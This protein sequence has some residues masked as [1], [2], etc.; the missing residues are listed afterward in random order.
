MAAS[1]TNAILCNSFTKKEKQDLL[2]LNHLSDHHST[3]L[4]LSSL[5]PISTHSLRNQTEPKNVTLEEKQLQCKWKKTLDKDYAKR[6]SQETKKMTKSIVNTN[7]KN[8]PNIDDFLGKISNAFISAADIVLKKHFRNKNNLKKC[9]QQK[10][11][12]PNCQQMRKNLN[13]LGRILTKNPNN[14][15]LRGQY[16]N[17]K[18]RYKATCKKEKRKFEWKLLQ[19]LENLYTNN[20]EEF[21]NLLKQIKSN[22]SSKSPEYQ[23]L[24]SLND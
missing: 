17:L 15:F 19:N 6:L 24:P 1:S 14:D 2:D 9:K 5:H 3:L 22:S 16:F 8:I 13:Q 18:R 10:W 21:W 11:Y 7:N 23:T 12:N 20:N 4:K